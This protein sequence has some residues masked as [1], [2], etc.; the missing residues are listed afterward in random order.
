MGPDGNLYVSELQHR[1]TV[2]DPKGE[3]LARW[4]GESS[5]KPGRF[6]ASHG[7]AVDSRGDVYVGEV[8]EGK[9]VQKFVRQ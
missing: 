6:V 4:G 7:I 8:L 3:V 5:R 9:R 1:V 2:V